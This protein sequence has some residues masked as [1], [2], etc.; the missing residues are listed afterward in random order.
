VQ[1]NG[2]PPVAL[3]DRADLQPR[4]VEGSFGNA[5]KEVLGYVQ[6]IDIFMNKRFRDDLAKWKECQKPV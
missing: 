6:T 5:K 2:S 4:P 3:R 1:T